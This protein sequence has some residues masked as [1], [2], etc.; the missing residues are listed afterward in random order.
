MGIG[1]SLGAYFE[2]P[3]H[4]QAGIE[5]PQEVVKPKDTGDDNTLPPDQGTYDDKAKIIPVSDMKTASPLVTITDE[6]IDKGM[7]LGMSFSGGGLSVRG[8]AT[9]EAL[10]NPFMHTEESR[11]YTGTEADLAQE[12]PFNLS[13]YSKQAIAETKADFANNADKVVQKGDVSLLKTDTSG[14]MHQYSFMN[15]DG[16]VGE[17]SVKEKDGGK[18]LD[19]PW[20]GTVIGNGVG[21]I[22]HSEIRSLF[23]IL[24]DEFPLAENIT[25]FRVSGARDAVGKISEATMRLR[26]SLTKDLPEGYG[27]SPHEGG[28]K[29]VYKEDPN[30]IPLGKGPTQ[31]H[32]MEDFYRWNPQFEPPQYSETTWN[33]LA[34]E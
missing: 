19:I 10:P 25:G 14:K 3:F 13:D 27:Y 18:T 26:P 17:L 2:S 22:G 11:P 32:A 28:H 12:I 31:A 1:T 5:T 9:R 29:V 34:S 24:K 33:T 30:A 7:N 23:N 15:K 21:T 8:A 20:I 4:Q 16:N 6:D